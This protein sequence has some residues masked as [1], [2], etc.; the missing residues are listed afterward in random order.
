MNES[1]RSTH[2]AARWR[3]DAR[4]E[5]SN[6]SHSHLLRL[7]LAA[8]AGH[9]A[10]DR[11]AARRSALIDLLANGRPHPAEDIYRHVAAEFGGD[12]WGKRPD[13]ALL[14]DVGAL[15][16]GGVRVAYSRRSGLEGY[17]LQ[18][19]PL[20]HTPSPEFNRVDAHWTEQLR[21]M[22][23]PEKNETAFGAADFALRQKRLI[24]SEEQPDWSAEQIDR[25]ARR[26]VFG[27]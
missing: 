7:R 15:R 12:P 4:R 26:L 13:E 3:E 21:A 25:E 2:P 20:T 19:P 11:T 17:Y 8:M 9:I 18:Y 24:L 5:I 1:G 6:P 10:G 23:V 14:R 27:N 16:R 22:S